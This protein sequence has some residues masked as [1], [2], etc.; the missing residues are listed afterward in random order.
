MPTSTPDGRRL[1]DQGRVDDAVKAML[2]AG[3]FLVRPS[4]SS[5]NVSVD[6]FEETDDLVCGPCQDS[7]SDDVHI[8]A[9]NDAGELSL[10]VSQSKR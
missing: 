1:S 2:D 7:L 8:A 5:T 9:E 6:Y 4:R 3:V 10:A